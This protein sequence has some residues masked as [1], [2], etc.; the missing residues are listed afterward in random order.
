MTGNKT[1]QKQ[2]DSGR[3]GETRRSTSYLKNLSNTAK[4]QREQKINNLSDKNPR[5][6]AEYI[7]WKQVPL[8]WLEW[9]KEMR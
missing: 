8:T 3:N 4:N 6:D 7:I 9:N 1:E 2:I 5:C